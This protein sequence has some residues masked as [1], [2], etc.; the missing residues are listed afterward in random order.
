MISGMEETLNEY[1]EWCGCDVDQGTMKM[2]NKAL[3]LLK[4]LTPLE[5]ALVIILC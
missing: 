1:K 4:K 2:Y 5:D 3:D